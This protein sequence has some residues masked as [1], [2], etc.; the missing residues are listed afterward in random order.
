MRWFRPHAFKV[1]EWAIALSPLNSFI[2]N[3]LAGTSG[4]QRVIAGNGGTS[5]GL[6]AL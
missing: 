5:W 3:S 6:F 2:F 1:E 4:F